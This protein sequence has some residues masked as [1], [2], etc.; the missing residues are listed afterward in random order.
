MALVFDA[1]S[2]S[3]YYFLSD[4]ADPEFSDMDGELD[5][6]DDDSSVDEGDKE[7]FL[8]WKQNYLENYMV[9]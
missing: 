1:Y 8:M 2:F 7:N 3:F 5:D 4:L 9:L 6:H